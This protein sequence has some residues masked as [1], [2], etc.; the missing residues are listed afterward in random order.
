MEGEEEVPKNDEDQATEEKPVENIQKESEEEQ[1][2][3]NPDEEVSEDEEDDSLPFPNAR[4][5]KIIRKVI[6]KDKQIR[7]EVKRELNMWLGEL[8][9]KIA[10]EMSNTQYGSVSLADF[11]RATKPY[12]QIQNILKDEERLLLSLEKIYVFYSICCMEKRARYIPI[13]SFKNYLCNCR[14]PV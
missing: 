6:G 3:T 10:K 1:V 14:V 7:S 13:R 5:V 2:E 9:K 12:D 8:L 4:V 11:K